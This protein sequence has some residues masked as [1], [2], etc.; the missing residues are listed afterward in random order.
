M[1]QL[2]SE[3]PHHERIE[4]RM[5]KNTRNNASAL[6]PKTAVDRTR[7]DG[8]RQVDAAPSMCRGKDERNNQYDEDLQHL[9]PTPL[10]PQNEK[11]VEHQPAKEQF[12]VDWRDQCGPQ[13][14]SLEK[15]GF[16]ASLRSD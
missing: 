6:Q 2:S 1:S 10:P 4:Q 3:S 12:F 8:Q 14:P 5:A 16:M 11:P 7:E 9:L 13:D 15:N